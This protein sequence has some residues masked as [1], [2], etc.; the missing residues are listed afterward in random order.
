[1]CVCVCVC[2]CVCH[3]L[4]SQ[5]ESQVQTEGEL[6]EDE[7]PAE[8]LNEVEEGESLERKHFAVGI[9]SVEYRVVSCVVL[10]MLLELVCGGAGWGTYQR[11]NTSR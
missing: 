3:R 2:V 9:G 10:C 8:V 7:L 6:T 5:Y 4:L 1:M 11:E